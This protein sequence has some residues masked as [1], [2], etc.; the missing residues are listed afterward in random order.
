M[1][2]RT[3]WLIPQLCHGPLAAV[4]PPSSPLVKTSAERTGVVPPTEVEC[5]SHVR[6]RPPRRADQCLAFACPGCVA[7]NKPNYNIL[8][9]KNHVYE[10]HCNACTGAAVPLTIGGLTA[11][12]EVSEVVA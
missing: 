2:T 1:S 5:H 11:I 12:A 9:L 10:Y 8:N 7:T 6:P 4:Q 3:Q